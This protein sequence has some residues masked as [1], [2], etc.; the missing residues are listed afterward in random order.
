ME[1]FLNLYEFISNLKMFKL[2]KINAKGGIFCA[3]PHG[4]HECLRG[5]DVTV[6][7]YIYSY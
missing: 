4:P 6:Y 2:I 3:E 7:I 1:F 5:T